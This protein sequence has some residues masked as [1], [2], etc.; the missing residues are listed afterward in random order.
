MTTTQT[1]PDVDI[2]ELL[3][4]DLPCRGFEPCSHPVE[5]LFVHKCCG[6]RWLSCRQC[7]DR[8]VN[9]IDKTLECN[10]CHFTDWPGTFF[11][12]VVHL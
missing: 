2:E 9:V 12:R 4:E 1:L 7:H 8:V 5:W 10:H 6:V 11:A 3:D